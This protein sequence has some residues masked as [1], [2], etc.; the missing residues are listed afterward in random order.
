MQQQ[1]QIW[2]AAQQPGWGI[3]PPMVKFSCHLN[4]IFGL[5]LHLNN[6]IDLSSPPFI[7]SI[8]TEGTP[9]TL[10]VLIHHVHFYCFKLVFPLIWMI[11]KHSSFLY[12]NILV[13]NKLIN[14]K[15]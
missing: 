11:N 4:F 7:R 3:Q 13:H 10:V 5:S 8:N 12:I 1:Q 2:N 6:N 15:I 9:N 14:I